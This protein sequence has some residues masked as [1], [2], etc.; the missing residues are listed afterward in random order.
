VRVRHFC[1]IGRGRRLRGLFQKIVCLRVASSADRRVPEDRAGASGA[2]G[3]AGWVS[4]KGGRGVVAHPAT[5]AKTAE[6][7]RT[8]KNMASIRRLL[9]ELTAGRGPD[10]QE[11]RSCCVLSRFDAGCVRSRIE[12]TATSRAA[13]TAP[14]G[15]SDLRQ[16]AQAERALAGSGSKPAQRSW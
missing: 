9:D 1:R 2:S 16:R 3:L 13:V 11:L 12:R 8:L 14:S 10:C 7:A 6:K 15:Q 4:G 5:A